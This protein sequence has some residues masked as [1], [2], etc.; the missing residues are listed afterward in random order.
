MPIEVK[1]LIIRTFMEGTDYDGLKSGS[2]IKNG[3]NSESAVDATQNATTQMSDI[4]TN[5]KKLLEQS[6]ER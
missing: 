5:L 3:K 1:E 6:Q 2:K 4:H